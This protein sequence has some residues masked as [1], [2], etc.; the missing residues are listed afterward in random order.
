MFRSEKNRSRPEM[1]ASEGDERLESFFLR[2]RG[3]LGGAF[4]ATDSGWDM[5]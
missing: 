3:S 4:A 5:V 1:A 2:R